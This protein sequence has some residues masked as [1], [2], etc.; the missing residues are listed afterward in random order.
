M[1]VIFVSKILILGSGPN[2]IE[3]LEQDLSGYDKIVVINNA[4]R[5]VEGWTDHIFPHDFP[6][7]NKPKVLKSSQKIVDEKQFVDIQNQ[8]GGFVYAGGTMAFTALYWALGYYSPHSIDILGC[9][10]VY[11]KKGSTHF[12]GTGTADPLREDISLRSLEAKSARVYAIALKQGCQI[13]NLSKAD[14]KLIAP[15]RKS[16]NSA[17]PKPFKVNENKFNQAKQ[18]EAALGYFVEDG[19]YWE[20][21]DSFNT[22]EIDSLDF[23]WR[24]TV[25]VN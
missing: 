6:N 24:E 13:A 23:L 17:A 10:M 22:D 7:Q 1:V 16:V 19:R 5:I 4:W 11:P 14:S 9:D 2:V 21:S 20:K 8:Y 15:R 18:K 12:Y 3:I 25:S